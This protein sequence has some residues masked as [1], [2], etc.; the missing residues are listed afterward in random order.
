MTY[1]SNIYIQVK[2]KPPD[3]T[4]RFTKWMIDFTI[5]VSVIQASSVYLPNVK[6]VADFAVHCV[7]CHWF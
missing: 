7:L 4:S 3:A 1:S 5:D 6:C 2:K